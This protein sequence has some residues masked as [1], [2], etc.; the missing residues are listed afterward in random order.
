MK[1]RSALLA[2]ACLMMLALCA[3]TVRAQRTEPSAWGALTLAK[4]ESGEADAQN[5]AGLMYLYGEGLPQDEEKALYWFHRAA[6][7]GHADAQFN[8]GEYH[9]VWE[10]DYKEA[11]AWYRKAAEQG[12]PGAQCAL[13][14]AYLDGGG[15]LPADRVQAMALMLRSAEQGYIQ[16]MLEM[17]RRHYE[18]DGVP[19]DHVRSAYWYRRAADQDD[20]DG[21]YQLGNACYRGEGVEMD[22]GLAAEWYRKAADQGN[23]LAMFNLGAMAKTGVGLQKDPVEA[24]KWFMLAGELLASA[25]ET[26]AT[27]WGMTGGPSG[28]VS[29][30]ARECLKEINELARV[31]T[32]EQVSM[33][34]RKA[35]SLAAE[36]RKRNSN[37]PR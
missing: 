11:V 13:A 12:H 32:P 16:A 25:K 26:G 36:L 18:G 10:L 37:P 20:P 17:G 28:T 2:A 29:G 31:M 34:Q 27:A 8:L 14:F 3:A 30:L 21:Q 35:L 22:K 7:Q 23:P 4:A 1:R 6:A 19:R 24:Y 15:G 33:A 5:E 9:F